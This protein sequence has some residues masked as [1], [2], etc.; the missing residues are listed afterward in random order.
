[1]VAQGARQPGS[2]VL[3][4]ISLIDELDQALLHEIFGVVGR[5]SISATYPYGEGLRGT[6]EL[7]ESLVRSGSTLSRL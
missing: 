3:D 4:L 2:R 1:V 6:Y 7:G 5:N